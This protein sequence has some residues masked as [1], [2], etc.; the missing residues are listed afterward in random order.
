MLQLQHA[1]RAGPHGLAAVLYEEGLT[2][3]ERPVSPISTQAISKLACACASENNW[4]GLAPPISE[5]VYLLAVRAPFA[6]T[7]V[8]SELVQ[9]DFG[10]KT[11]LAS[12]PLLRCV[13]EIVIRG[14]AL[15]YPLV[16]GEDAR[17]R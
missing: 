11:S 5:N 8:V 1:E 12:H 14:T 17:S 16:S 7:L 4:R 9:L 2:K 6:E 10:I 13:G 3:R 15:S